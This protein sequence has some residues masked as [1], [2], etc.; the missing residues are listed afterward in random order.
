MEKKKKKKKALPSA[1]LLTTM[2]GNFCSCKRAPANS[3]AQPQNFINLYFRDFRRTDV[4]LSEGI[5]CLFTQKLDTISPTPKQFLGVFAF[6]K[7]G[8]GKQ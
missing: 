5:V 2:K 7:L 8:G 3:Q 6:R 4:N 1:I